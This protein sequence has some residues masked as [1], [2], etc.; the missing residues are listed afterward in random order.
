MIRHQRFQPVLRATT[1]KRGRRLVRPVLVRMHR[2]VGLFL[3]PVL[4]VAGLTGSVSVYRDEIDAALNPDLFATR[5]EDRH[6]PLS[7][8]LEK[9][10]RD[11]PHADIWA[12]A[13]RPVPRHTIVGYLTMGQTRDHLR[14]DD[15]FF[16]EPSE[17]RLLGTRASEGCCLTRRAL[18]PFVYRLHYSLDLGTTGTWILGIAAIAWTIDCLVGL[19]L[20]FPLGTRPWRTDF[21]SRWG[22]IWT[23]AMSRGMVRVVFDLHRTFALWLW[24]VLLG[25]AISGVALALGTQ[26]FE[27]TVRMLLPSAPSLPVSIGGGCPARGDARA[28]IDAAEATATC[29]AWTHGIHD[30]PSAVIFDQQAATATF[31]L[32][33]HDGRPPAGLGSP[34]VTVDLRSGRVS[35]A[36]VPGAGRLADLVLQVQDPWHSGRLAGGIGRIVVCLS[37]IAVSMLSVT[38]VMI[39]RRKRVAK[40]KPAIVFQ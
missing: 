39:W 16:L 32:F 3:A 14:A 29:F 10:R 20:T 8:L 11:F 31:Y 4:C 27:P 13:Y 7:V 35:N 30:P 6:L 9:A 17:G 33:G 26:V 22:H 18:M 40:R 2:Y 21:W 12:L 25:I 1:P 34:L 15:E 24:I 38:G 36:T 19:C 28:A 5:G 23:I 37:G